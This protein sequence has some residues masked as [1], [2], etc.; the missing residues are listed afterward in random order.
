MKK[1]ILYIF[2]ILLLIGSFAAGFYYCKETAVHGRGGIAYNEIERVAIV[3]LD[4]GIQ[5]DEERI[6][7]SDE[8]L[9]FAADYVYVALNEAQKGMESNMYAAYIIIPSDFSECVESINATPVKAK[10]EYVVNPNLTDEN[11]LNT[12]ERLNLFKESLNSNIACVYLNSVLREFHS[13]QDSAVTIMQHDKTDLDSILSID[14]ESIFNMID[15]SE[16]KETENNIENVDLTEYTKNN[17]D[18]LNNIFSLISE[19]MEEGKKGYKEVTKEYNAVSTQ[20]E[21]VQNAASNYNPLVDDSG[22]YV[23]QAGLDNLEQAINKYNEDVDSGE[24]EGIKT[25]QS[26]IA[27]ICME[28]SEAVLNKAQKHTDEKLE[29]IQK[30]NQEIADNK[31]KEWSEQQRAYHES[32]MRYCNQ[33]LETYYESCQVELKG[34]SAKHIGAAEKS[35]EAL[36]KD[37]AALFKNQESKEIAKSLIKKHIDDLCVSLEYQPGQKLPDMIDS[38]KFGQMLPDF[39][40]DSI[41]LPKVERL[42][43]EDVDDIPAD[44]EAGTI[45]VSETDDGTEEELES[46]QDKISI[47]VDEE[48][49]LEEGISE[50]IGKREQEIEALLSDAKSNIAVSASDIEDVIRDEIIN[51]ISDENDNQRNRLDEAAKGMLENM[52][53]YDSRIQS[54]NPYDY[55]DKNKINKT[56]AQLTKNI[57]DIEAAMNLKNVE[58]YEF[59]N[60]LQGNTNENITALKNDMQTANDASKKELNIV[61]NKLKTDKEEISKEDDLILGDF[62]DKLPYTRLG[63]LEYTEMQRFMAAPIETSYKEEGEKKEE[64]NHTQE[65]H[66]EYK[67]M[68]IAAIIIVLILLAIGMVGRIIQSR[69]EWKLLKDE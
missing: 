57:T 8:M 16:M 58:Y 54:F 17:S 35:A 44:D 10:I 26:G 32:L 7:Y 64:L 15:F 48:I 5:K 22:N 46:D 4:E 9:R 23:Y 12:Q 38:Q 51:K 25:L 14:S 43:I 34:Q 6:T 50:Y 37:I 1:I 65:I 42:Q 11:R 29:E 56:E 59:I 28:H 66:L 40:N 13:V 49:E 41:N 61:I 67:W 47:D 36:E 69:K 55:I 27:D 21:S 18:Q 31:T 45:A 52:Q 60:T 39:E 62:A 19:G 24:Q 30:K 33:E 3:N 68:I 20:M 53:K 63:T 2:C